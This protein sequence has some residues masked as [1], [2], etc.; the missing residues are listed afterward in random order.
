MLKKD[1]TFWLYF[2]VENPT[3]KAATDAD[4]LPTAT[5]YR[6]GAADASVVLTVAKPATGLYSV[7]GA[8]P[9][10]YNPDDQLSIVA[11]YA[12][13]AV[14]R[15]QIVMNDQIVSDRTKLDLTQPIPNSNTAQTVGDALLAA[16]AQG[17]GKWIKSGTTLNLYAPDGS[18]IIRS[19][20]LDDPDFPTQRV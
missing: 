2:V 7:T 4:A 18:T 11:S 19:F 15:K 17:F 9:V 5:L 1:Q 8:I 14:A 13:S 10:G 6:N 12:V 3:T 16:R 20:V